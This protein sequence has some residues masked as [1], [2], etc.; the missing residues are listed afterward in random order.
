MRTSVF[1][2]ALAASV[3]SLPAL[4]QTETTTSSNAA[5]VS[6]S[7]FVRTV[8]VS[9]M[10]EIQASELA[11]TNATSPEIKSFAGRMVTDHTKTSDQLK[12]SVADK[13]GVSIP[14]AMDVRHKTMLTRLR[15]A[16]GANF[17]TLY[18]QQQLSAHRQAVMLFTGE[19]QNGKD[20]DLKKFAADTLPTLQEHLSMAQQLPK[21]G[22]S[23]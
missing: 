3:F 17:D 16:K 6:D 5:P 19:S 21:G 23:P 8:A 4:S 2:A 11:Q 9:D 10:F 14:K 15:A 13:K 12:S 22:G 7:N 18:A 20:E 1:A